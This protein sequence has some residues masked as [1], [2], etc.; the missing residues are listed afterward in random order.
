M[1]PQIII[2]DENHL[3]I[4]TTFPRRAKSLIKNSKAKWLN[5]LQQ[6][7][8]M[9]PN[10]EE[11][12]EY[13]DEKAI[14]ERQKKKSIVMDAY[15]DSDDVVLK[16]S[17]FEIVAKSKKR[18]RELHIAFSAVLW[19]GTLL[20]Y[21]VINYLQGNHHF[22]LNPNY[23][24]GTWL[25]FVAAALIECCVEIYFSRKELEVLKENIDLRQINPAR[26]EMHLWD[27]QRKLTRK[28][29]VM[30]S[31]VIWI[32]LILLFFMGGYLFSMWSLVWMVFL[33]G[34]F[35]ELVMHFLRKLKTV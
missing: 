28:I 24:S 35:F 27:Y 25:L 21:I 34:V 4:G 6:A 10:P 16:S 13:M 20:L 23:L 7:I 17:P 22:T 2:Y 15:R 31:A 32:P 14:I 5:E 3:E 33:F 30:S 1:K 19:T 26:D 9:L 8:I 29:R 11:R 12:G 18:T